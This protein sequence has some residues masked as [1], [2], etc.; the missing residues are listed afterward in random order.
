[1]IEKFQEWYDNRH[2]Y[3]KVHTRRKRSFMPSM[4]SPSEFLVPMSPRM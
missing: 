2:E 3:A 4:F 1:M